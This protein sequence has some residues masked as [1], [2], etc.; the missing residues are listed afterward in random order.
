MADSIQ[1]AAQFCLSVAP[2]RPEPGIFSDDEIGLISASEAEEFSNTVHA[3][4]D[5]AMTLAM[6]RD[7]RLTPQVLKAADTAAPELMQDMR[8]EFSKALM[9][10]TGSVKI[11]PL[12]QQGLA[13]LLGVTPSPHYTIA[14][15]SS[16]TSNETKPSAKVSPGS[17]GDTGVNDRYSM[18]K[19]SEADRLESGEMAQ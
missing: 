8:G 10:T 6:M 19:F 12:A 1:R 9:S 15:Q 14:L 5:P 3:A 7:G 4:M 18:S 17:L 11:E 2:A 13:M 16:W